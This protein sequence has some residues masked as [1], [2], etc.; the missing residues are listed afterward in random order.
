MQV[1]AG[2]LVAITG[3][4]RSGKSTKM[5]EILESYRG[6]N[7]PIK[8]FPYE[9]LILQP[10]I[11]YFIDDVNTEYVGLD[12]HKLYKFAKDNR[13]IIVATFLANIKMEEQLIVQVFGERSPNIAP[14]Y[15]NKIYT[16]DLEFVSSGV[17]H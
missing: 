10:N 1:I 7:I 2:D 4:T 16:N 15:T 11:V 17:Y 12:I 3:K 6:Q 14:L 8:H 13:C 9:S 5:R